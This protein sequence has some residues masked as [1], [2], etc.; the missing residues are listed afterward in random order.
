MKRSTRREFLAA[1]GFAALAVPAGLRPAFAVPAG[2]DAIARSKGMRFGMMLIPSD[3]K[4]PQI[5]E[6]VLSQCGL[7]G[8]CNALKWTQTNPSGPQADYSLAERFAAFASEHR[9]PMR[10][11]NI[12]WDKT[13]NI[14]KWIIA[15]NWSRPGQWASALETRTRDLVTHFRGRVALWDVVNEAIRPNTGGPV[16][17]PFY[18]A[19]GRDFVDIAFHTAHE[20]DPA[21]RLMYND[22]VV[23]GKPRHQEG[24]LA[25]ISGMQER[26]VPIDALGIQGHLWSDP[27]DGDLK[28]WGNFLAEVRRLGLEINLTELDVVDNGLPGN[29]ADR[30]RLAGV[31]MRRFLDATLED[32]AVR[33]LYTWSV[34]D[35]FEGMSNLNP[36][37]D[38]LRRRPAPF[39]AN[40]SPK[41]IFASIRGALEAAP[42]R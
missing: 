34:S 4:T 2:L 28:E 3:L 29:P 39:D 37:T 36:R 23:P 16:D 40:F 18:K 31:R 33:D 5:V 10:G 8:P 26:G 6:I 11:H 7:T 41:P 27:T 22:Y 30:D 9:M 35:K 14:P 25:L 15:Q 19:L 38:G 1:T 17:G 42:A 32:P 21:A 20:S 13:P 24:I 12:I